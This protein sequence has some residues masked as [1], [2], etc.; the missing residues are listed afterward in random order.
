MESSPRTASIIINDLEQ[1]LKNLHA[2]GVHDDQTLNNLESL[3]NE[4]SNH[5]NH[6][7]SSSDSTLIA[8]VLS[9]LL[10]T[11]VSLTKICSEKSDIIILGPFLSREKLTSLI[12]IAKTL[13]NQIKEFIKAPKL[14]TMLVKS[15]HQRHF[16]EQIRPVADSIGISDMLTTLICHKL[17]VKVLTGGDDQQQSQ[18]QISYDINDGLILAVYESILKQMSAIYFKSSRDNTKETSYIKVSFINQFSKIYL[19]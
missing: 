18:Q 11:I 4:C 12:T 2:T 19:I 14:V 16:C 17:L 6:L 7:S 15:T 9:S 3:L 10:Q 1:R 13:H 5:L 8:I